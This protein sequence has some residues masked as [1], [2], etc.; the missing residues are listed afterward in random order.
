MS[1]GT[2]FNYG[3]MYFALL[4][5]ATLAFGCAQIIL[6]VT[7]ISYTWGLLGMS[8]EFML[9]RGLILLFAGFFF[10]SSLKDF[11][12]IHQQGKMVLASGMIWII[13]VMEIFAM[14][15]GSIPGGEDGGWF[16][17]LDGF[18]EAYAGPYIPS[19]WLLPFSLVT[20]YYIRLS[21]R[22]SNAVSS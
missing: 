10:L 14:I 12:N 6:G 3:R 11:S 1:N 18:L 5:V 8:G 19:L 21:M 16:N 2:A 17:T 13:A 22:E 20:L 15:T 9:W 7:G 4:G